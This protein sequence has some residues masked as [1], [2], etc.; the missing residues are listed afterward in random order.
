MFFTTFVGAEDA[1]GNPLTDNNGAFDLVFDCA[2]VVEGCM[3][4]AACNY[5]ENA[6]VDTDTCE[7]W[8]CVCEDEGVAVMMSMNDSFGDGWNGRV[9]HHRPCW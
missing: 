1:D 6:N 5:D 3:N 2:D 8:S 7:F 4:P 9:L